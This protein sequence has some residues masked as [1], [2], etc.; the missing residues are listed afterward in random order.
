MKVLTSIKVL[1]N[2]QIFDSTVNIVFKFYINNGNGK[3]IQIIVWNDDI[4]NVKPNIKLN[5]I[6]HLDGVQARTPKIARFNNGNVPYEQVQSNTIISNLSKYNPLN[7]SDE[8]EPENVKFVTF[9]KSNFGSI[10]INNLNTKIGCGSLTNGYF[11]LEV[12]IIDFDKNEYNFTKGDKI[13]IIGVMQNTGI[14]YLCI[15]YY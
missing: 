11:K 2:I 13:K 7:L 12:H 9:I 6:I 15:Y 8:I 4:K 5:Y 14:N 3:R 1:D 10:Y